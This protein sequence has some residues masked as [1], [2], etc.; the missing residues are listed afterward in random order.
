MQWGILGVGATSIIFRKR[1]SLAHTTPL[2]RHS[3]VALLSDVLPVSCPPPR[4]ALRRG[5]GIIGPGVSARQTADVIGWPGFVGEGGAA[6]VA[7]VVSSP[8]VIS[9]VVSTVISTGF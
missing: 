7:T 6:S 4:S 9:A 2:Q 8:T 1:T 3:A 5:S